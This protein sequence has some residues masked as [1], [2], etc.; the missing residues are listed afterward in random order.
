MKFTYYYS[1]LLRSNGVPHI[2]VKQYQY[3]FNLM[4][5]EIRLDEQNKI[6][7]TL[8]NG[9]AKAALS[10]RNFNLYN[11]L[12]TLTKAK[13]PQEIMRALMDSD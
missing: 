4:A 2:G 12:N 5:L 6:L 10:R 13:E 7:Q 3:I 8:P 9:E 11:K 1:N